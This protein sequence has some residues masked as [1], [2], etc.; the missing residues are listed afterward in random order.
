MFRFVEI[1]DLFEPIDDGNSDGI[2]LTKSLDATSHFESVAKDVQNVYRR[3]MKKDLVFVKRE[4]LQA[5]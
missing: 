2:Y 1:A 4:S 3:I 5:E